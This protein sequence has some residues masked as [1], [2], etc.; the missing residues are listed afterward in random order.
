MAKLPTIPRRKFLRAG[1]FGAAGLI[2]SRFSA[3]AAEDVPAVFASNDMKQDALNLGFAAPPPQAKPFTLWHWMDGNVTKAGI[4]ADLEAMKRIGLSGAMIYSL[5]YQVPP[6]PVKYAGP[7]WR[8][9]LRHAAAEADRLKL[10]LGMHNASGWSATGG[11]W[12]TPDLG[13]Q[14]VVWDETHIRGPVRFVKCLPKPAAGEYGPY[15]RDIAVLAVRTPAAERQAFEDMNVGIATSLPHDAPRPFTGRTMP[16]NLSFPTPNQTPQYITLSFGRPFTARSLCLASVAGHGAVTCTLEVS[17]DG[18]TYRP[19]ASFVLPRRGMPNINFSPVT[20][21]FFRLAFTGEVLDSI[22]FVVSRLDLLNGYRLPDWAAKA[23]FALMDRFVPRWNEDCP[24]ELSYRKQDII[25]ISRHMRPDGTLDWVAPAGDWTILRFG[26]A[27]N[28]STS[29]HPEPEGSGLEID[30]MNPKA[31]DAHFSGVLNTALDQIGPF[32]GK[33]FSTLF[34]DSYEAGPQNWTGLFRDEFRNRCGYDIIPFLPTLTGRIVDTP[35]TTERVLW[36]FRHIISALFIENYYGRFRTRCHER[37][38]KF[39]SEP[40]IG[41]FGIIEAGTAGD[42]AIG[43]FWTGNL[44]PENLSITRRIIA[45]AQLSGNPIA[46]AEAF[47]S[48]FDIDRFTLDPFALKATG[49]AQF[50]EGVTRFYFHRFAHQPWLDKAPGMTMGPYG[51]HFD[52]TETWWEPGSAWIEYISRSQ[53]L[54]QQGKPVVDILCFDGEDGQAMSRWNGSTLPVVPEGYNYGF[55]NRDF[56]LAAEVDD[57]TIVL[58]NGIRYR[59]LVL[60]DARH[61]TLAVVRKLAALVNAGAVVVGL[62]PLF[63]PSFAEG[64]TSDREYRRV[65][66]TL[67]GDCDGRIVTH[68]CSGK[69]VVYW[70]ASIADVMAA[71]RV[72][73]DFASLGATP[74]LRFSHH[75]TPDADIYFVSNQSTEATTATCRFRVKDKAPELWH[76]DTGHCEFLPLYNC[77]GDVTVLPL[78]LEP[79][80]SAFVVFRRPASGDRAIAISANL[81]PDRIMRTDDGFRTEAWSPGRFSITTAAGRVLHADVT[82][83]PDSRDIS[84]DWKVTFPPNTGAPAVTAL[85]KLMPLS[86]DSDP[87]VRFFSGTAIYARGFNVTAA[88]LEHANEVY[89]DLGEVKNL[90]RLFINHVDFGV[91]WKPPYRQAITA[92]LRPGRN[93]VEVHVTNLWANRLI[94]DEQLPDDCEWVAVPDRGMVIKSWPK[95]FLENKPRPSKRT[96]FATWKFFDR[97]SSLPRSGLIG[98]VVLRVVRKVAFE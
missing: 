77:D 79:S 62:P 5:S 18:K 8:D 87:G 43:E 67:W 29:M 53:F 50:C 83:L 73:P 96:T 13:M 74:A 3:S 49:D 6:G 38:L 47:T 27:P 64:R 9:M 17:D 21:R 31:V 71:L 11:P 24:P 72:P 46:G 36:D 86:D 7:L 41:P 92:A 52:R 66:S 89:L 33:S 42:M 16:L 95:W 39:A 91:M 1:M 81:A 94:G 76:P 23:G 44:Y 90:A 88:M 15:Y 65:V 61:L 48:R 19:A 58:K 51:L 28:G 22:P 56:L 34:V 59:L 14:T 60:P 35:E 55:V 12:I 80:G 40:Y 26:Y 25:D 68:H 20:A 37:G 4:T 32:V 93:L 45:S 30:K 57:G 82:R 84:T 10:E 97:H 69:G 98:P 85:A 70:G 2:A 78:R 54:L 63:S 75:A